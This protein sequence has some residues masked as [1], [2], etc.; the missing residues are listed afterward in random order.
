MKA[1]MENINKYLS[2]PSTNQRIEL[3]REFQK[4]GIVLPLEL[5]RDLFEI[6]L[7]E[8]EKFI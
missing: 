2:A 7:D 6:D 5:V 3:L 1:I 8:N 4:N